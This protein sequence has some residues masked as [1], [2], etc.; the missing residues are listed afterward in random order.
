MSI[1]AETQFAALLDH[2]RMDPNIVGLLLAGSR[3]MRAYVTPESDYDAYVILREADLL[4][5]YAERFPSAHGD[6]VEYI[7]VSLESFRTHALPGTASRWN[8]YT[9]AHIEPLI[10]KL[11]GEIARIVK[12]KT[13]P[14][15]EDPREF[16]DGYLNQYY[17]SRKNLEAG[18]GLEGRLDA[19]ESI[20]WF[21]D[22]LFAAH[23]RVRPFN[24]WLPWELSAPPPGRA[25]ARCPSAP[26]GDRLN[27]QPGRPAQP[28][29]G[30]RKARSNAWAWWRRRLLGTGRRV[31]AGMTRSTGARRA[32]RERPRTRRRRGR[33]R[34]PAH[35]DRRAGGRRRHPRRRRRG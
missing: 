24:K 2:A 21:L 13:L 16:L 32:R 34:T 28:F 19:A 31:P 29:P 10:D 35:P 22:F 7:L 5:E 20:V 6:P 11:D 9:F 4:D 26:R 14:G 3:G 27:R 1:A 18:R 30:R 23:D 17:R 15:P 8:A 12:A 33:E 25:V